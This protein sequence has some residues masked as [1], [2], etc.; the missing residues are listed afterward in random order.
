MSEQTVIGL[1]YLWTELSKVWIILQRPAV[2]LQFLAI[3][4]SFFLARYVYKYSWSRF[5]KNYPVLKNRNLRKRVL[6]GWKYACSATIPKILWPILFLIV[7]SSFALLFNYF[8]LFTG[9]LRDG[10]LLTIYLI[11]YRLLLVSLDW[12]FSSHTVEYYTRRLL[13]PLFNLF[14]T[15]IILDLFVDLEALFNI[16]LFVLFG[17]PITLFQPIA[18]FLGFYFWFTATT[19]FEKLSIEILSSKQLLD[20]RLKQI[21]SFFVR[22]SL[23]ALGI[24]VLFGYAGI[25]PTAIAAITGGLSV[26]IGF[27]LREVISNFVSGIWLLFE[28]TLKPGDV[29]IVNDKIS[30]VVKLGIRATTV[31]VIQ[32]N[33]EEI[34]PNQTFFTQ[35]IST[36]TGSNA[37]LAHSLVV[38]AHYNCD[39]AKVSDILLQVARKNDR[40]LD[41][42]APQVSALQFGESSIDFELKYWIE[43]PL[44]YKSI[45]SQ[46]ICEIWHA[47]ADNNIEI[48]YPQRDLHI[49]DS[50]SDLNLDGG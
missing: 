12:R 47:F 44:A 18:I 35:N 26:G 11:L 32:D 16:T 21:I 37:L 2:Q 48:P 4:I 42:P 8:S 31:Q 49:R 19:L 20:P 34:I 17:E 7:L 1:G 50:T 29:I 28:G 23:I 33:S 9:Y 30:Q 15:W 38:G 27:G 46:L 40:V 45:T 36:F 10:I 5:Q 6:T 24:V 13:S 14:I 25:N 43:N 39:P 3:V 22:Y 41:R